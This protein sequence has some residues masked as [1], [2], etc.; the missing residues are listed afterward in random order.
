MP[1]TLDFYRRNYPR[2]ANARARAR[3]RAQIEIPVDIALISALTY[4]FDRARA[5]YLAGR[6]ELM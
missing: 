3:T 4:G 6:L 2:K 5:R 1:F